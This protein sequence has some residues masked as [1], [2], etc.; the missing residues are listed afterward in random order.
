MPQEP[1]IGSTV[2]NISSSVT[3]PP[4][5][6]DKQTGA[7]P[8]IPEELTPS[9]KEETADARSEVTAPIRPEF[10][11]TVA[12]APESE[13]P[14]WLRKLLE[15]TNQTIEYLEPKVSLEPGQEV[16]TLDTHSL[17][18][19]Y[20][21][22]SSVFESIDAVLKMVESDDNLSSLKL[23]LG[24]AQRAAEGSRDT[25]LNREKSVH[26]SEGI[27]KSFA[28]ASGRLVSKLNY[29]SS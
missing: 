3:T 1:T 16:Q 17:N 6:K 23:P 15:T 12:E 26:T 8:S 25:L 19:A 14:E 28:V 13:E 10:E 27:A 7:P 24:A 9:A 5:V 20:G 2:E 4:S 18:Q 29:L 22:A 21:K 11:G